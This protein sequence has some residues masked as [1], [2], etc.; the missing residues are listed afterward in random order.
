MPGSVLTFC[1]P[2]SRW[3]D[4]REGDDANSV[5]GTINRRLQPTLSQNKVAARPGRQWDR[6]L[7]Q[8]MKCPHNALRGLLG[9]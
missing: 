6:T 4:F 2:N 1:P 5:K 7:G 3:G 9:F 8:E